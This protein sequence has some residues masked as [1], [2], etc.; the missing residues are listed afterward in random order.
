MAR[1]IEIREILMVSGLR[2]E[3][4]I[5]RSRDEDVRVFGQA[6]GGIGAAFI[7]GRLGY[8]CRWHSPRPLALYAELAGNRYVMQSP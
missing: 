6:I 8:E 4:K 7:I 5:D 2:S 1:T 3:W